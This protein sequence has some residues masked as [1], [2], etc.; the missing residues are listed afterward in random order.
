M[1][2]TQLKNWIRMLEVGADFTDRGRAELA[3]YLRGLLVPEPLQF[4]GDSGQVECPHCAGEGSVY[5]D[6]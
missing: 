6:D 4:R 1:A 5:P 2:N 3:K